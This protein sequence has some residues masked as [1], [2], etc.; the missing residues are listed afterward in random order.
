MPSGAFLDMAADCGGNGRVERKVLLRTEI[1]T[2]ENITHVISFCLKFNLH[3]PQAQS[4]ADVCVISLDPLP[5]CEISTR[6]RP[7]P[8]PLL[9]LLS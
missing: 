2:W 6:V 1:Q 3:S 9:F 4:P 8:T 7:P 5:I